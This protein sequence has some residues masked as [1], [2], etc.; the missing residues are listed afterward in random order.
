M[1][2][3]SHTVLIKHNKTELYKVNFSISSLVAWL[4]IIY[5]Y[6]RCGNTPLCAILETINYY[7]STSVES[8]SNGAAIR[9]DEY[10]R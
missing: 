6:R 4:T 2:N 10:W 8:V 1:L 3:G 9:F 7:K 5:C